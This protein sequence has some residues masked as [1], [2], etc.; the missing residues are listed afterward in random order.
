MIPKSFLEQWRLK[1]PWQTLAMVEQDLIISRALVNLY[2]HPKVAKSLA[3]R[4]GTALNKLFIKPPARYSEDIDLVQ[5]EAEPI[6]ETLSAIRE[7]LDPWLGKP[8]GKLTKRSAKL[9][10][11]YETTDS[12]PGK[13]KIEINTT[14][15]FHIQPLDVL[16]Y[17]VDSEWF[18]GKTD[19]VTYEIAELMATKLSA[20]YQRSKGRD[21]FDLWLVSNHNMI[22][23]RDVL[24]IFAKYCRRINNHVTRAMFEQSLEQKRHRPDFTFDILPLLKP[25]IEWNFEEAFEA[26]REGIVSQLPGD[27]WK[28]VRKTA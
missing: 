28:G 20:L 26:V 4:G 22:E 14:E 21:L 3:F 23:V 2:S 24:D 17:S 25:E 7:T 19:I 5:I 1:A 9:T 27:P 16:P 10:Y 13:L 15:H 18:E 6:G 11:R 12:T 8:K